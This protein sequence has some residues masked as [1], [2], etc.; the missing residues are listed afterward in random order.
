LPC[1]LSPQ[2]GSQDTEYLSDGITETLINDLSKLPKL[3]VMS[4]SFV[5]RY[6][7]RDA[8][9]QAVAKDLNVEAVVTGRVLQGGDQLVVSAELIDARSNRNL[10]GDRYDRKMS[11]LVSVQQDISGAIATRLRE[12]L[13]GDAAKPMAKGGTRDP[14]AYQLYLKGRYYWE[15]RTPESMQKAID[16]FNQAIQRDPNYALAYV[17]LADDYYALPDNAPVSAAEAMPRA[18]AAA[19]KALE[20]DDT[21]ADPHAVLG[22]VYG[23][24]EFRRALELNPTE[25]NA[26]HWYA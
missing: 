23:V 5:F 12:R 15:K 7:A 26:H 13:S 19:R 17:G 1:C 11:D 18:Q 2:S 8:D 9:P 24:Q 20:L 6:K 21:L 25:A 16:F 4:R 14:E 3:S 22:G 10:W